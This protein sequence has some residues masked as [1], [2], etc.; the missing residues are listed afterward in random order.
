MRELKALEEHTAKRPLRL[1][2]R[3]KDLCGEI[4]SI[5]IKASNK[6]RIKTP[7]AQ[8]FNLVQNFPPPSHVRDELQQ[9]HLELGASC[10]AGGQ[11]NQARDTSIPHLEREDG[12]WFDFTITVQE[13]GERL[14]LLAYAFEIRLLPGMGTSFL[15]FDLN[16][17]A[18]KTEGT[19]VTE[20]RCHL[21]PGSDD[22][23]VPSPLMSPVEVLAFLIEGARLPD[24]RDRRAPTGFDVTWVRETLRR[25]DASVLVALEAAPSRTE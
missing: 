17:P 2:V 25:F 9:R 24:G 18:P 22:M 19:E 16:L 3:A 4:R 11:K 7:P 8:I 5:L 14:D 1:P 6:K 12:A 21:H 13:D 23:R 15:R 10:I 20:L